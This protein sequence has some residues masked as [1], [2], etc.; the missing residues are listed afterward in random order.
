VKL[1]AGLLNYNRREKVPVRRI[2]DMPESTVRPVM[3]TASILILFAPAKDAA[4]N[5]AAI[6]QLAPGATASTSSG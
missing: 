3:L 2:A 1:L 5:E 4:A 6:K